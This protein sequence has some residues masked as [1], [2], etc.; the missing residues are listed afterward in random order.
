[1]SEPSESAETQKLWEAM[2]KD[3]QLALE[4]MRQLTAQRDKPIKFLIQTGSSEPVAITGRRLRDFEIFDIQKELEQI[5]PK[6][7]T[8]NIRESDLTLDQMKAVYALMDQTISLA[9][10]ITTDA[11]KE[12]GDMRIRTALYYK[13]MQVSQPTEEELENLKKFRSDA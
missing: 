10:R 12:L 4:E 7:L 2:K 13:I 11:L 5:N 1:M 8:Q 3:E 9:T 6:L